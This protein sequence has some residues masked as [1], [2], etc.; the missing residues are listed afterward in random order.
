VKDETESC[1]PL[2]Q[3]LR[4]LEKAFHHFF[5]GRAAYPTFRKRHGDQSAEYTSSAF[6]W[7]GKQ[8]TL[9]KMQTPLDIHWSR[10]LP[11]DSRPTTITSPKIPPTA[12]LSPS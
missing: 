6:K 8:L 11:Q 5:E 3:A 7:D 1:V 9:A 2:Q 12:I 10:P 4:H